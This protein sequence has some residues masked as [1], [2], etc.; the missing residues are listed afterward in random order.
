MFYKY[1]RMQAWIRMHFVCVLPCPCPVKPHPCYTCKWVWS[2]EYLSLLWISEFSFQ[3][4]TKYNSWIT[5]DMNFS[6][7]LNCAISPV[8]FCS[9]VDLVLLSEVGWN[10][11]SSVAWIYQIFH[12]CFF[13]VCLFKHRVLCVSTYNHCCSVPILHKVSLKLRLLALFTFSMV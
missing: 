8:P 11:P 13:F 1:I 4:I 7:L 9:S 10:C 5:F 2:M 6:P 3:Y 12:S